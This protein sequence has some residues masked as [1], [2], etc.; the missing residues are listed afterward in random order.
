VKPGGELPWYRVDNLR[1]T[2]LAQVGRE[3][4]PA[5]LRTSEALYRADRESRLAGFE[6]RM[7]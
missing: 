2:L 4:L 3:E 5:H 7:R 1:S 6:C